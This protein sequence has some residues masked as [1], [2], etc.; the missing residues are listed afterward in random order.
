[1]QVIATNIGQSTQF[2]HAGKTVETGIF[3]K[4]VSGPIFLGHEMV[5]GD[6]VKDRQHHGGAFKACYI[7]DAAE[8]NYWKTQYP[9]QDYHWGIFGEN[10]TVSGLDETKERIGNTYKVGNALV[11]ISIPREPCFKLGFAFGD[12]GILKKFISRERPGV[13]LQVLE[14]G[15]VRSGDEFTLTEKSENELTI[16]DFYKILYAK[17]KNQKLLKLFMA[18]PHIPPYKKERFSKYVM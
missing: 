8:Y 13:Y 11:R 1:M 15:E 14:E 6:T 2:I 7:F 12:Q 4:P 17:E 10:L 3:K 16:Q 5:S 9:N 18:H